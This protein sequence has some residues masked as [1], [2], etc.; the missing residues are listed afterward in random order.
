MDRKELMSKIRADLPSLQAESADG[1][2]HRGNEQ[3]A[4]ATGNLAY[5]TN[6]EQWSKGRSRSKGFN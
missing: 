3:L 4:N 2:H 5:L 6:Q 1:R